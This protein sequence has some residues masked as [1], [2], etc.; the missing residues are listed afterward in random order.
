MKNK[1]GF[2]L[3]ELLG[4]IVIISILALLAFPPIINQ[5][6]KSRS[7]VSDA[8]MQ[9]LT[10]ATEMYLDYHQNTFPITPAT[11]YCITLQQLVDDDQLTAPIVDASNGNN[12]A[13]TKIVKVVIVTNS[14]I[15]YTLVDTCP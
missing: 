10:S 9:I 6:K 11:T 2:T 15:T 7:K 5:I 1:K 14:N 8:T 3:A 4:V 12:Y 13:L